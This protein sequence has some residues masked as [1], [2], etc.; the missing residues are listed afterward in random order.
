MGKRA[1]LLLTGALM[2]VDRLEGPEW[3]H[4][5]STGDSSWEPL[6]SACTGL[7]EQSRQTPGMMGVRMMRLDL[8]NNYQW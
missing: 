4:Q 8:R 5:G 7:L 3:G 6:E 1:A 2:E